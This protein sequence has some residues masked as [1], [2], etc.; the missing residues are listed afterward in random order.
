MTEPESYKIK[1]RHY[2]LAKEIIHDNDPNFDIKTLAPTE[3]AVAQI[4]ATLAVADAIDDLISH[5]H[6]LKQ[7]E[8]MEKGRQS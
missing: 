1:T 6:G 2:K 7:Q 3:L 8:K 4:Q 5:M